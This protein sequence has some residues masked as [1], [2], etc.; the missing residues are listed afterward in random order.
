MG[1]STFSLLEHPFLCFLS[2]VS[3]SEPAAEIVYDNV[4]AK[5]PKILDDITL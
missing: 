2:E 5:N 1:Y 4:T 3:N